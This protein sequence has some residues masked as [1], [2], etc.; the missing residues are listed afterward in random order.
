MIMFSVYLTD[1]VPYKN[2][3]IHGRI[4]DEH[5][6]KMS[7][8]KGNVID[9]SELIEEYG[10]DA[11]RMGILVGANTEAINTALDVNKVRGYRNFSN[12]IWN[13]ARFMLLMIEDYG[14]DVPF[15][16]KGM[17]VGEEDQKI[18]DG[19][20]NLTQSVDVSLEK[21][22]FADAGEAVY[23]FMWHELAD[24]Y[25]E[26]VKSRDDKDVALSVLSYVYMECLKLLHPFMPFVTEEI[27]GKIP[28]KKDVPIIISDW[29]VQ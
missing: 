8:S 2:V 5:G 1:A 6:Q 11:L 29:P 13:M 27:W 17:E 14:K 18:L 19:L 24:K 9:P 28:K 26:H 10:A 4:T 22:R 20:N 23:Q 21:Y 7:K 16:K 25:I 12:K 15:Y 3:Y